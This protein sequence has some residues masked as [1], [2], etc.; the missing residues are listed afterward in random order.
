MAQVGDAQQQVPAGAVVKSNLVGQLGALER[1]G[2][3]DSAG[4]REA[5]Q[6]ASYKI[7]RGKGPA[8]L[9][10]Y[11]CEAVGDGGA[12]GAGGAPSGTSKI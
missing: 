9:A 5:A 1:C 8:G 3:S 10:C 2:S 6:R 7:G 11:V 4:K 12:A